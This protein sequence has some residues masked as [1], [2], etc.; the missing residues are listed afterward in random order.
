MPTEAAQEQRVTLNDFELLGKVYGPPWQYLSKMYGPPW[1]NFSED[2]PWDNLM[3]FLTYAHERQGASAVFAQ[4]AI[5]V[6]G[7]LK[8][9]DCEINDP[10]L[11]R[12]AWGR[13][14]RKLLEKNLNVGNNPM[15]PKGTQYQSGNKT[16]H[17]LS[18]IEVIG[19]LR[20]GLLAVMKDLIG[21][22]DVKQ[23][24][25]IITQVSGVGDKIASFFLRDVALHFNLNPTKD[26][27]LLQP[28]D[29]W[30][31]RATELCFETQGKQYTVQEVKQIIVEASAA[32]QVNPERVNAGM[33]YFGARAA[34]S[35]YRLH[36]A[37]DNRQIFFSRVDSYIASLRSALDAY[38]RFSTEFTHH[39][40]SF[41]GLSWGAPSP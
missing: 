21:N 33:W 5:D 7:E 40:E 11:P 29:I 3:L 16:V 1:H 6:I 30:V 10:D 39:R 13:Y 22:N 24:Y 35:E 8:E 28:V 9:Q 41:R 32:Q 15:A 19:P 31:R 34:R 12:K 2:D 27:H 18:A 25:S 20:L 23:A 26:R 14:T 17:N 37:M 4:A 36:E 38:D